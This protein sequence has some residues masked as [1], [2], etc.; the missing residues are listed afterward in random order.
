[1]SNTAIN[2]TDSQAP[3]TE[4]ANANLSFSELTEKYVKPYALAKEL[5]NNSFATS[6]LKETFL[7][8]SPLQVLVGRPFV[9]ETLEEIFDRLTSRHTHKE[10]ITWLK[11]NNS[12]NDFTSSELVKIMF[13]VASKK[14]TRSLDKDA[15]E[16]K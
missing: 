12:N 6:Q 9:K 3:T 1:M 4:T 5:R 15:K 2:L 10:F 16:T 7:A 8:A 13:K 14:K 11:V